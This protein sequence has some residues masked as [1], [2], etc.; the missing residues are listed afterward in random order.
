MKKNPLVSIITPS[1]NQGKFIRETIDSVLGQKYS[2]IEYIVIDGKSTDE[3]VDV[4]KSYGERIKWVSEKDSG[5]MDALNKGLKMVKG[6]IIA[7]INSDDYYFLDT[8]EKVVKIFNKYPEIEIVSGDYVIINTEG[9]KMLTQ[10]PVVYWKR[11]LRGIHSFNTLCV[12]NYINQPS[13]FWRRSVLDKVG[14]FNESLH[15]VFDYEYW[16]RALSK[17][18]SIKMV[19]DKFCCYRIHDQ[20]KGGSQ[21]RKRAKEELDV[22]KKFN[23][24][25]LIYLLHFLHNQLMVFIYDFIQ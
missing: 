18:I 11:F 20:S 4:L 3:T 24:N 10:S 2:N 19:N 16:L 5:Q 17:G 21:Y 23:K 12:A 6:D 1:Y 9:K 8:I 7:F 22:Q 14:F 15:Y 13:T 25:P